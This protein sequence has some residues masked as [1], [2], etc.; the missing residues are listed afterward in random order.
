MAQRLAG[1]LLTSLA[2]EYLALSEPHAQD[3]LKL[4]DQ[5]ESLAVTLDERK[6]HSPWYDVI[7]TAT[8]WWGAE[9]REDAMAHISGQLGEGIAL[10][11][12]LTIGSVLR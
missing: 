6:L 12:A 1:A 5:M 7:R 8:M 4:V 2:E 3:A 10:C 11:E 9:T